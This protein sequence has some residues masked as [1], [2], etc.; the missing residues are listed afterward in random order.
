MIT[1]RLVPWVLGL[2]HFMVECFAA[3]PDHLHVR[4]P[5]R[6]S[7]VVILQ[8][9]AEADEMWSFVQRKANRQ[10]IWIAMDATTRQILGWQKGR[11]DEM[12]R[13][14]Y[15]AEDMDLLE[16]H[17][18]VDFFWGRTRVGNSDR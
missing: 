16:S 1:L 15:L 8:L 14:P 17:A 3:C 5:D 11:C 12:Q 2:G 6:P 9:E 10:W 7:D 18:T 4:L 13:R